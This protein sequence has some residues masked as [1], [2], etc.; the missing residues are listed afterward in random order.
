ML[1]TASTSETHSRR[2]LAHL[3]VYGLDVAVAPADASRLMGPEA[4]LRWRQTRDRFVQTLTTCHLAEPALAE[5][6]ERVRVAAGV[7]HLPEIAN[8]TEVFLTA[9]A[10]GFRQLRRELEELRAFML[11]ETAPSASVR[12]AHE[13][14]VAPPSSEQEATSPRLT[15]DFESITVTLDGKEYA[16]LNPDAIRM[17][18][19]IHLAGRPVTG[20]ELQKLPGCKGKH[21]GRCLK[22]LPPPLRAI[23]PGSPGKDYWL[24]LPSPSSP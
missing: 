4:S 22:K 18:H 19:V 17:L 7:L 10:G 15:F 14:P 13:R 11:A 16:A 23:V 8:D 9:H 1:S 5:R 21:I 20:A 3:T 6:V 24:Q 12:I 2:E